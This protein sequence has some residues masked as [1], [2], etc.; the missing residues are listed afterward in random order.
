MTGS[1]ATPTITTQRLI[2]RA[3]VPDDAIA[4]FPALSDPKL[5]HYWSHAPYA[6][7][8]ELRD[9]FASLDGNGWRGWVI[10]L[11]GDDRAIGQLAAGE[12]RQKGVAEIGYFLAREAQGKGIAREA[13]SGLI[14]HL[15]AEGKRRVFA[16]T[17][18]DNAGSI[19]LLEQL[20]FQL[21]GR[22]RGEWHTHIGVRDSL[23]Y[24]LL[25]EEW[26]SPGR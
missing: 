5:M 15:F 7:V 8:A 3:R 1:A 11:A 10:T 23:I 20:G 6:D 4:L 13:V 16:D 22:L 18:P 25:A 2:L 17:D 24:G 21:E 26:S 14:D 19:A 12:K 9:D